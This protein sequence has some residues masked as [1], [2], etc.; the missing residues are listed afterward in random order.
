[1][2]IHWPRT[3]SVQPKKKTPAVAGVLF[4]IRSVRRLALAGLETRVRFADHEDLATTA[5][6]L[7]VAMAGLRRLEGRK[8]FHGDSWQR[9][10]KEAKL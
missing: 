9:F 7:A 10:D 2:P 1:V 4:A 8:D 6:D 3:D 5:N